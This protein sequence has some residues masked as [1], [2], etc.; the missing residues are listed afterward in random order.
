M[1]GRAQLRPQYARIIPECPRMI[2]PLNK[3]RAQPALAR[4]AQRCY[5]HPNQHDDAANEL[6]RSRMAGEQ[7][8]GP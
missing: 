5:R 6:Q 1:K 4:T 2:N 8:I 3:H 7:E